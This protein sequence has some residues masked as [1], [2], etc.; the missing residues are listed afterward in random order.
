MSFGHTSEARK[1][2]NPDVSSPQNPS[3]QAIPRTSFAH[4]SYQK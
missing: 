2:D 3:N 4:Q 1:T